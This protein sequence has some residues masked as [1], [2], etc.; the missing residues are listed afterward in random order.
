MYGSP[1]IDSFEM[2]KAGE[3]GVWLRIQDGKNS[4][5]AFYRGYLGET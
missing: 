3:E 4:N 5:Q 1:V 2:K